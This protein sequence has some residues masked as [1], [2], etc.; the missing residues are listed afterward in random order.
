MNTRV[1]E[2]PG[3]LS[4]LTPIEWWKNISIICIEVWMKTMR[5]TEWKNNRCSLWIHKKVPLGDER[6][7]TKL[8]N[9]LLWSYNQNLSKK[10]NISCA[11][12][13]CFEIADETKTWTK[14]LGYLHRL[15]FYINFDKRKKARTKNSPVCNN[16]ICGMIEDTSVLCYQALCFNW[17]VVRHKAQHIVSVKSL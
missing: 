1:A 16:K 5:D 7:I 2:S 6:S 13:T 4:G 17:L 14:P 15:Q 12:V 8:I 9:Y 10:K 11:P 3:G